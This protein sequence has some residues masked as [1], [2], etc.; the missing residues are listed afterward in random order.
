M[1][2]DVYRST[3][4]RL[5]SVAA[6]RL[7]RPALL[8][9]GLVYIIAGLYFRDP[10]K[11]DDVIGLATMMTALQ[12]DGSGWLLP[13][14]GSFAYAQNGPMV[15]WAGAICIALFSPLLSLFTNQIDA[16][17]IASRIPNLLW[18]LIMSCSV[19]YGV[20]LLGRRQ[21]AQPLALPFGGEPSP[22]AYGRILADAALLL[23]LATVGILLR[24]HETS[25]VPALLAFQALAFYA[26]TRMLDRPI[27]GAL[28]LAVALAG[29]LLTRG[30]IGLMPAL[31]ASLWLFFPGGPL[32]TR[33]KY[34]PYALIPAAALMLA[35]WIPARMSD[36]YWTDQWLLWHTSSLALPSLGVIAS[37]LRDLPWFLWPTWPFALLALWGWRD[38]LSAPHI[39]IPLSFL[40][41]PLLTMLFLADVFEPEYSMMAVPSALLAAFSLPT[42]RRAV[43]NT[44]DWFS[45]MC[46]SLAI[47]TVW[48]GWVALHSGWP[49]Q[50]SENIALQ[51]RGY[52]AVISW[53]GLLLALLGTVFWFSLVRWRLSTHPKA[54]WRG[55]ILSSGGLITTWLL[56]ASLWMPALDYARSYRD[57]S[58]EMKQALDQHVKP[59]ECVRPLM[60]GLGQRASLYV[61]QGIEFSFSSSCNLI[62][63]QTSPRAIA[64]GTAPYTDRT[65][66]VLWEGKRTPDRHEVFRLLRLRP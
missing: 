32:A 20:Y 39:R 33:R 44:L 13:Q 36:T 4:A 48:L 43:I 10:W 1:S 12:G 11:A 41:F 8:L 50:I 64:D 54:L 59:G 61:F 14:I 6:Q 35:W 40:L 28:T 42:L 37:L 18:M 22:Q 55:T 2:P 53:P 49:H 19:W 5:T 30:W 47:A 15:T 52:E 7:P 31:L 29:L 63:Q 62:L 58:L 27:S 17:I 23:L 56:L 66:S 46:F 60:L 38:W 26:V 21:E 57:V 3:P 16:A 65:H 24:M 51:T 25:S 9:I 34:L 45:V